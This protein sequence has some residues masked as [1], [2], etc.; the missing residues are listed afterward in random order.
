ML[1]RSC[2]LIGRR[3]LYA[4][5]L[6]H[7]PWADFGQGRLAAIVRFH[8][9]SAEADG[10]YSWIGP[11]ICMAP[12][13]FERQIAFLA[14]H[15]GCISMDQLLEALSAGRP[16]PRNAVVVTFDDGYRDNYDV[17]FP[18][19][20]RHKVPAMFYVTTG[21]LEGGEPLWPS[22]AR[23]LRPPGRLRDHRTVSGSP[24]RPRHAGTQGTGRPGI[25]ALAGGPANR[26]AAGRPARAAAPH[27]GGYW[28][29]SGTG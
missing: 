25:E 24:I 13:V 26:A 7:L 9:V 22:Q 16:L 3:A 21:A 4:A 12:E 5:K 29:C 10:T 8:S 2:K 17:A 15:Y 23:Y 18:I 20:R 11:N 1:A 14:R 28:R 27:P 19:L 6:A